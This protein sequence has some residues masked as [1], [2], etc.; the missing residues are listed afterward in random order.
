MR[1]RTKLNQKKDAN[2]KR[3]CN[4][5]PKLNDDFNSGVVFSFDQR[6]QQFVQNKQNKLH[7]QKQR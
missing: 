4:F 3:E 2:F 5:A 7:T 6:S 1:L